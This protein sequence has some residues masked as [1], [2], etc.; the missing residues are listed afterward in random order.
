VSAARS[1]LAGALAALAALAGC[2]VLAGCSDSPGTL[3]QAATERAVRR[4]VAAEVTPA[5]STATCPG[6][7]EQG[8]G[9]TFS[10]TVAVKGAGPLPVRV[11]QVD[12]DGKLDVVPAA[13]VVSDTDI[14]SELERSLKAQFDRSFQAACKG[15]A[16]QIR[17]PGS[18]STCIARDKTS[19]RT[20]T[21]TVTDASGTLSF[22]L[23]PEAN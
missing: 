1:L 6:P 3:D 17:K 12:G 5:V 16:W 11:R 4:A 22:A 9:A 7:I 19:R 23:G 21:V 13:A 14:E 2:T 8:K 15:G 20:V 10:C 18:T